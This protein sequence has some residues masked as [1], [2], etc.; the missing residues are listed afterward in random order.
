MQQSMQTGSEAEGDDLNNMEDRLG[1]ATCK[2]YCV[3]KVEQ[4]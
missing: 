3:Y 1:N 4:L 2:M